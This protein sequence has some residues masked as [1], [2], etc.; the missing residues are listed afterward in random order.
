MVVVQPHIQGQVA[1]VGSR[2]HVVGIATQ[3]TQ[4]ER[5][6]QSRDNDG[7]CHISEF[8]NVRCIRYS[9]S[10]FVDQDVE[11]YERLPIFVYGTL[12]S[13]EGNH[14]HYFPREAVLRFQAARMFGLGVYNPHAGFPFAKEHED[15]TVST[16]GELYWLTGDELGDEVRDNIDAL[17]GFVPY[18]VP[19]FYKRVCRSALV[20]EDE[21]DENPIRC[22][23]YVAAP[24]IA[25]TLTEENRVVDGDWVAASKAYFA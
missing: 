1:H 7:R 23:V 19:T 4:A 10:M 12:R 6:L 9:L 2:S 25:E 24:M 15:A 21:Y 5:E 16:V 13:G 17:E 11:F 20:D 18:A 22:W 3:T 14:A 8:Q